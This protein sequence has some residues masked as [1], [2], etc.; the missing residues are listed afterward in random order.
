MDKGRESIKAVK[1][2]EDDR[3]IIRF[4]ILDDCIR[5][6]LKKSKT[7][8]KIRLCLNADELSELLNTLNIIKTIKLNI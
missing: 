5:I 7:S 1:S 2:K 4:C 8:K 6:V 3:P